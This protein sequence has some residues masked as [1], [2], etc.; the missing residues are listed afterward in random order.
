MTNTILVGILTN[1]LTVIL[2]ALA[3]VLV[4]IFR[5][6]R[7]LRFYGI[8]QPQDKIM[9]II[10]RLDVKAGGAAA[11][12][13]VS[14]GYAGPAVAQFDYEAAVLLQEQIRPNI[15]AWFSREVRDWISGKFVLA[16][17]ANPVIE[18]APAP[19]DAPSWLQSRSRTNLIL[20]GGPAYNAAA[21]YFQKQ[22]G[23]HFAF[24][25]GVPGDGWCIRSI[26][27]GTPGDQGVVKSRAVGRELA[28]IQRIICK[29]TGVK[30]TMCSG[31]GAGATLA[32]AEWLSHN[33]R[34]LDR[35]CR[36]GE[37]GIL[38]AFTGVTDPQSRFPRE[39]SAIVLDQI[40]DGKRDC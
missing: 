7:I 40:F 17:A 9:I 30:I 37:Y 4:L 27:G 2:G 23:A 25:R 24:T 26:R 20:L 22:E 33:Y 35:R 34:Q 3:G 13:T 11:A 5:Y 10:P 6:K 8:R 28:F 16:A 31:T 36:N 39:I 21:G 38:L 19:A 1:Y 15:F 14:K 18:L 12:T 29:D 32:G